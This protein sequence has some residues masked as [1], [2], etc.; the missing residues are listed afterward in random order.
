MKSYPINKARAH[1]SHIIERALAGEPQ[2]VTRYGKEAVVIVSEQEWRAATASRSA[3][4]LGE[5]LARYARAGALREGITDRPWTD[6]TLGA[7]LD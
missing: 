1:F 6:R 4:S 2:R 5:L 7:G 3:S